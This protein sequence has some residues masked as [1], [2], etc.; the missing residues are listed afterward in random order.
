MSSCWQ[1]NH[2]QLLISVTTQLCSCIRCSLC[3]LLYCLVVEQATQPACLLMSETGISPSNSGVCLHNAETWGQP[4]PPT[5]LRASGRIKPKPR[6]SHVSHC[7]AGTAILRVHISLLFVVSNTCIG[8]MDAWNP[9]QVR[10]W[11]W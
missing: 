6:F 2:I 10:A 7:M 11:R 3:H 9:V 4:P 1:H 5:T 8:A